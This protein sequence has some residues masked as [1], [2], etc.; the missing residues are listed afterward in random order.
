[1][2]KNEVI[3]DKNIHALILAIRCGELDYI[4]RDGEE[5]GGDGDVVMDDE[6]EYPMDSQKGK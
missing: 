2:D 5:N 6:D 3:F 1:M 4:S